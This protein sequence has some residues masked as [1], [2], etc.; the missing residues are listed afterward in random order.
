MS[1]QFHFASLTP[2]SILDALE[3][4]GVYAASG[5]LPLN[6]YEN[7]VYQFVAEDQQRYVVKFYR[8]ERWSDAQILEEHAYGLELQQAEIPVVNPLP[9][10]GTTL[11]HHQQLRFSL[12]PSRGGRHLELDNL[13][14]LE[15][16]GRFLGRAH[17]VGQA[18]P[19]NHRPTLSFAE[20]GQ[21]AYQTLRKGDW[22][23]PAMQTPFFVTL[24]NLLGVVEQHLQHWPLAGQTRLHGDCHSGNILWVEEQPCFIDLDDARQG[25]AIQDL[26]MLL[27]G[28]RA[29]KL[30]Q[31]D[32]LLEGYT[33]FNDFDKRQLNLIEPLRAL[34]MINY[35]AWLARRWDDP[36]F[37][38]HFPWFATDK[39][40]EQQVLAMKE[41]LAA[42]DEP[43]LELPHF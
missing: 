14:H 18:H 9:F 31:L 8:P 38:H 11:L 40:W 39:Y 34:R 26:W 28:D 15:W 30:L 12:F 24:E 27:S 7:R 37:P 17:Q 36:A 10:D 22:V 16:V 19:F 29:D 41:Q 42:L 21:Q 32:V 43:V 13:D 4:F 33:L 23:T 3:A 20:F 5:L 25:P 35:M 1:S 6:S 2:D